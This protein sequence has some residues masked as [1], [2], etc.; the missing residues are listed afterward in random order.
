MKNEV[1]A[2]AI[3]EIDN[4][5]IISAHKNRVAKNKRKK[6]PLAVAACLFLVCGITLYLGTSRGIEVSIYG[7]TILEQP[8]TIEIPASLSSDERSVV[9]DVITVPMEI[10]SKHKINIKVEDGMLEVY[11]LETNSLLCEG[12]I[13]KASDSVT[14]FWII[15]EPN[16]KQVYKLRINSDAV[17]FLL[18]YSE[19][20]NNWI[21]NK[22]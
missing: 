11:S 1:F 17:V 14:V 18:S 4:E 10:K 8:V 3:T 6:W 12:Q 21:L 16:P 20:T 19:D 15:E 2:R 22:Q 13:C 9:P 7:N 5:L